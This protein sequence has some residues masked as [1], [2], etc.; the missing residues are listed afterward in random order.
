MIKLYCTFTRQYGW[1][2]GSKV[3]ASL[4]A[5]DREVKK[6]GWDWSV[7]ERHVNG[8]DVP[9]KVWIATYSSPFDEDFIIFNISSEEKNGEEWHEVKVI[10]DE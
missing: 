3:F 7:M 10:M 2:V 4:A 1:G 5:A 6:E 8:D 9:D